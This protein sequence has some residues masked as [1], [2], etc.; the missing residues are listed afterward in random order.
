[1][2]VLRIGECVEKRRTIGRDEVDLFTQLVGDLNPIHSDSDAARVAGFKGAIAHGMIAGSL[3]SEILGN[4]LPGPGAI[5]LEQSFKFV[6]PI[7]VGAEVRLVVEVV[8][9]REDQKIVQ[10]ATTCID[11][12]GQ[13]CVQG[14]ATLLRRDLARSGSPPK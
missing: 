5:Y 3:F 6:A 10:V 1:M 8:H 12:S 9:V 11:D 4:D 7:Y 13:V 14:A 2:K